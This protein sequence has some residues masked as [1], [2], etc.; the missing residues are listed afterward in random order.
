MQQV[1]KSANRISDTGLIPVMAT[2]TAPPMNPFSDMGV[3]MT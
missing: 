3:S 2:P 1:K